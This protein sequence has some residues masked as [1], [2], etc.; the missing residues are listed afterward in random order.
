MTYERLAEIAARFEAARPK[1]DRGGE[2]LKMAV[3]P[4]RGFPNSTPT[5]IVY[6][7][8]RWQDSGQTLGWMCG[9]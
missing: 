5:K 6:A 2:E 3:S 1:E 7:E 4:Q 9:I 8:T